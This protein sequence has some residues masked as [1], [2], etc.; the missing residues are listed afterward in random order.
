MWPR[1]ER[2]LWVV[3]AVFFS[4]TALLF[5]WS[6]VTTSRTS[7]GETVAA[8]PIVGTDAHTMGNIQAPIQLFVYMD[9]DCIYCKGF[10]TSTLPKLLKA[11]GNDLFIIYRE[12]P[13]AS[14]P[15]AYEKAQAAEC[16]YAQGGNTA[17]FNFVD[18]MYAAM[19]S[20][21]TYASPPVVSAAQASNLSLPEFQTCLDT[22]QTKA[23]VNQNRLEGAIAGVGQVPSMIVR[24]GTTKVLITGNNFAQLETTIRYLLA[25]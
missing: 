22:G 6:Y 12:F 19:L 17:F 2:V 21:G 25:K 10:H 7:S 9:L 5:A 3:S 15:L 8:Y 14:H 18:H 11:Y 4:I 13:L 24:R 20:D 1:I 23:V 16:A